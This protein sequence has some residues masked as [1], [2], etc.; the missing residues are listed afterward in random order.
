MKSY[1]QP[2]AETR[3]LT[4]VYTRAQAAN[5]VLDGIMAADYPVVIVNP[6]LAG[7]TDTTGRFIKGFEVSIL[8]PCPFDFDESA[9]DAKQEQCLKDLNKFIELCKKGTTDS[10]HYNGRDNQITLFYDKFDSTLIGALT[11]IRFLINPNTCEDDG[12]DDNIEQSE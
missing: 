9:T 12:E 3:G 10:F 5:V 8:T 2:I 11:N 6:L 7:T 1:C 4:L